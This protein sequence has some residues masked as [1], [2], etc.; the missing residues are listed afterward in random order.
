MTYFEQND[1]PVFLWHG[2]ED[3]QIPPATF[4][5]FTSALRENKDVVMYI[6]DG[7]HSPTPEELEAAYAEIFRFLDGL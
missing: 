7:K 1:P 5:D 3:K 6:P 4:E 2:G